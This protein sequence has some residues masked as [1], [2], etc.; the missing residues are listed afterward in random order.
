M[1]YMYRLRK[2]IKQED[3]YNPTVNIH[4]RHGTALGL[5]PRYIT[6]Q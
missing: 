5:F 2:S 3:N 1:Q 4:T 6:G